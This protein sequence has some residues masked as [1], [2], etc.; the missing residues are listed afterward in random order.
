MLVLNKYHG[1]RNKFLYLYL[2]RV[3]VVYGATII[4]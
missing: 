1:H 4:L 3:P 2:L